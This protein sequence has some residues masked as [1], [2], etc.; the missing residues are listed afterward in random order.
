MTGDP[1]WNLAVLRSE[2]G[3]G[4]PVGVYDADDDVS[5]LEEVHGW[6]STLAADGAT[7]GGTRHA[8]GPWGGFVVIDVPA[9][10]EARAMLLAP[11]EGRPDPSPAEM[12]LFA[13]LGQH[14]ATTIE[15]A[16]LYARL[17]QQTDEL[18][19]LA[20]LQTD[21]LR[22]VTHDLQTPLTSIR[23][24]AAELREASGLDEAA[25]GDLDTI[26]HQA[27][28]L[29]RMVGQLLVVSRL[30]AGA[31]TPAQE[32]FRVE[33]IVR[34]TWE[35]LRANRPMEL[36]H[37]GPDHLVVGDADRLEQALWAVMDNAV[38]Y[39]PE[40]SPLR[41]R[42]GA[43]TVSEGLMAEICV[44][45]EGAGMDA[46]TL[47]HAFDQF[48]RAPGARRLSPD[49]SG[50]GLYAARGLLRAMGGEITAE[51]R[52]GSGTTVRITL[53]AELAEHAG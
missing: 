38:K 39:S 41:I 21:F 31:L 18:N 29:R 27:D 48:F 52:A 32:V 30:E 19:R 23:A 14:A 28:R 1:T 2:R 36:V 4:L 42:L 53:P 20:A 17:R 15:H 35:A 22:G 6:A 34:R 45:D 11:W 44:E 3:A 37:E 16:L 7:R 50:V 40:G 43:A 51:S 25:R 49:G 24:L 10:E 47:A 8:V 33:P 12:D 5:P 46:E 13:L 26:T 9:G